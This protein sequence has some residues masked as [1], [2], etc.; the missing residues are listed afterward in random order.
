M[1]EFGVRFVNSF[2]RLFRETPVDRAFSVAATLAVA[3]IFLVERCMYPS[4]VYL[5]M[6]NLTELADN[7]ARS[8]A[9]WR[10]IIFTF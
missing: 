7:N 6:V 4:N 3:H 5:F 9:S 8:L 10:D 2:T 1:E